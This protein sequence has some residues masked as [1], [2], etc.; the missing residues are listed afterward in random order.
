MKTSDCSP[1]RCRS[2]SAAEQPRAD[3]V[4]R[5]RLAVRRERD[6]RRRGR[7]DRAQRQPEPLVTT[8]LRLMQ[9][10]ERRC[11]AAEHDRHAALSRAPDRD[12]A[13]VVADALLLLERR[14][15]LLVDDDEPEPRHRRKDGEARAEH[16]IGLA[17]RRRAPARAAARPPAVGCAA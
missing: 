15:V 5:C 9:R 10:L 4:V 16:E 17:G 13:A 6:L 2:A 8:T 14:V 3:A 12:V 1:R 7:V 11:R